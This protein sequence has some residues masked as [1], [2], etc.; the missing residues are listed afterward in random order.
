MKV[1]GTQTIV[2]P[3][4]LFSFLHEEPSYLVLGV[5]SLKLLGSKLAPKL[6]YMLLTLTLMRQ[7]SGPLEGMRSLYRS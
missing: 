7:H 3:W 5:I 2:F 4:F 6:E 1:F